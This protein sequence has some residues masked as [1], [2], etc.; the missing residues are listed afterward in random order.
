MRRSFRTHEGGHTETQGVALGWYASP[1]QGEQG[2]GLK[3]RWDFLRNETMTDP[4][5]NSRRG[6]TNHVV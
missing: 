3:S 6:A 5:G 2:I 1:L 4:V